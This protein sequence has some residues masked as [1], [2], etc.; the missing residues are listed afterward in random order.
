[1]T[2]PMELPGELIA[3]IL[4]HPHTAQAAT[5][6]LLDRL[7]GLVQISQ[8]LKDLRLQQALSEV[9][10]TSTGGVV[11][12][13]NKV[14]EALA[15]LVAVAAPAMASSPQ[16]AKTV[17]NVATLVSAIPAIANLATKAVKSTEVYRSLPQDVKP[18]FV[19]KVVPDMTNHLINSLAPIL[20]LQGSKMLLPQE[21]VSQKALPILAQQIL[22][23]RGR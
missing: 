22:Q 11:S 14:M 23:E 13:T 12:A 5:S 16:K 10:E 17:L 7:A 1:M 19:E 9:N 3:A 6:G 20:M 2:L 8:Q 15:P 4:S 18:I 21:E